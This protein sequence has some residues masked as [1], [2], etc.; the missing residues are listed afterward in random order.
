VA[1]ITADQVCKQQT[2]A[3]RALSEYDLRKMLPSDSPLIKSHLI[4][5]LVEIA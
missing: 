5:R 2:K 3:E 1:A 4:N